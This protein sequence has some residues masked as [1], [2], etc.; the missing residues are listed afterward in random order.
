MN[1]VIAGQAKS[2]TTGLYQTVK[3]AM[4]SSGIEFLCLFE[5]K[6]PKPWES[7]FSKCEKDSSILTKIMLKKRFFESDAINAFDKRI[8]ITRDPRDRLLSA[9]LFKALSRPI[10]V[11]SYIPGFVKLLKEKEKNP[12]GISFIELVEKADQ[13]GF[14]SLDFQKISEM[15][16]Y[17]NDAI[18]SNNFFSLK[19]EAFVSHEL[20][21]LSEYL[22]MPIAGN[23]PQSDWLK[24]IERSR[25]YGEWRNWFTP[26]DVATLRPLLQPAMEKIGYND[27]WELP[28]TQVIESSTS[29]EYV[30]SNFDRRY[31][32]AKLASKENKFFTGRET[33]R[34]IFELSLQRAKDGRLDDVLRVAR[35][36]EKGGKSQKQDIDKAVYWYNVGRLFGLKSCDEALERLAV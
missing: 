6:G 15:L 18:S 1:I 13:M 27:D 25:G 20:E 21:P 16:L 14:G 26:R 28:E 4:L 12:A 30:I 29:S 2:G 3:K 22:G 19:Y 23:E 24:H 10:K 34:E 11:K 31:H 35:I 17:Q 36:Y 33:S 5:P 8:M 9:F 7:Y 32:Q